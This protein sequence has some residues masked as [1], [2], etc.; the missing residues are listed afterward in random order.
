MS[1]DTPTRGAAA[2]GSLVASS[3]PWQALRDAATSWR[4]GYAAPIS[5]LVALTLIVAAFS[6]SFITPR[7]LVITADAAAPILLLA[8]AETV[9]ILMGSIDLSV[10]AVASLSSVAAAMLIDDTWLF[11]APIGIAVG[12]GCGL[13]NGLVYT[14][15][16]I[17]SFIATLGTLGLWTGTSLTIT[18]ARTVPVGERAGLIDWLGEDTLG[19]PNTALLGV[20]TLLIVFVILRF[21]PLGRYVYAIGIG[22]AATWLSGVPVQR[23]KVL[24]FALAGGCAGLAGVVITAQLSSGGP[25]VANN[26][27]LPAIAAVIVGGTAITGGVGGVLRTAI[28]A[29][30]I[31][32]ARIGMDAAGV[33]IFAQ[34]VVYGAIVILAVTLTIDRSK[35]LMVK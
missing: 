8:L 20:L 12:V 9:V 13:V 7:S 1:E 4:T 17:P 28:G 32:V 15:A 25:S 5:T 31:I 21:T 3:R 23:Y 11:A 18:G 16:R 2:A 27:L 22:E 10:H 6:P 30:I 33:D 35:I 24:A 19:F 34:Q 26:L 29:L 14:L